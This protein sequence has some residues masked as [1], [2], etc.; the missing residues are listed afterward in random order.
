VQ[1]LIADSFVGAYGVV[2]WIA[3]ELSLASAL[4]AALLIEKKPEPARVF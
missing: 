1:R 2:L 4:S 3:V